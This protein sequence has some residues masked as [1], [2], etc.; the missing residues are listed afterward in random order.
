MMSGTNSQTQL[1]DD[2]G[3]LLFVIKAEAIALRTTLLIL[4]STRDRRTLNSWK[5]RKLD[6]DDGKKSAR[7]VRCSAHLLKLK[8]RSLYFWRSE[9]SG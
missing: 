5:R 1:H 2:L 6:F 4:Q 9:A 7:F 8:T 3:P